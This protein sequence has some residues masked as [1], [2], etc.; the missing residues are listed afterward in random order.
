MSIGN[1]GYGVMKKK[2]MQKLLLKETNDVLK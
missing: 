2:I 1:S